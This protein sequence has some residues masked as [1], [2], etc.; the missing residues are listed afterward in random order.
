VH[1]PGAIDGMG[2][3]QALGL[4]DLG[5]QRLPVVGLDRDR[6]QCVV[7]VAAEQLDDRPAAEAAVGVVEDYN[8]TGCDTP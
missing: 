1:A 3:A 2:A 8:P 4:G 7:P 5:Q 6:A